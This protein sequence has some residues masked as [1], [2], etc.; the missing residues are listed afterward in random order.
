MAH[1]YDMGQ[2][3]ICSSRHIAVIY[4]NAAFLPPQSLK[5][6]CLCSSVSD[7]VSN[8][9]V[10]QVILHQPCVIATISRIVPG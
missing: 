1:K 7:C 10:S 2:S 9:L 4:R 5:A 6:N 3:T 8:V